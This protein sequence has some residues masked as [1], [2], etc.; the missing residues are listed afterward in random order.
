MKKILLLCL[1]CCFMSFGV[2]AL[3]AKDDSNCRSVMRLAESIMK[4]KQD[5][6]SLSEA[7]SIRDYAFKENP[8]DVKIKNLVDRIIRDA[9]SQPNYSTQSIKREQ[10]NEFAAKYYLECMEYQ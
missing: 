9:Y 7:L 8:N 6:S 2:V 1:V 5:G 4:K 3:E 10:L